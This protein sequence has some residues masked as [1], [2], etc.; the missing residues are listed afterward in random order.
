[1]RVRV[2]FFARYREATGRE[3]LEID[4]PDDG[5]V[6][7]AWS[8]VVHRHPELE[9]YRPFTLF[10]VG[11]DYVAPEHRLQAG[12]ELC[13]FPPVS[14]GAG[15]D[16]YQVVTS[17]L[18]PDT[19]AAAVDHPGAGGIVVFSGVVRNETGGRPVKY[20]EYEA[21][22]PMA[23]AKMR[24]IGDT[25][26]AR[27]P[28]VKRVAMLHRVGRLEIGESSVLIAVSAAHRGDAFEACRYA[29]DTLKQTVPVW[30]KEHFEDGEIWVGLQGG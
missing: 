8:A 25:V 22:S 11:H 26:H 14:G 29:I 30:K 17:P 28:G 16:R 12:D 3:R 18:S 7:S 15:G 2:R 23:E 19:A 5:T 10:A 27:W 6:E 21:H 9:A 13:L 4:L 24:E 20:L 1:M